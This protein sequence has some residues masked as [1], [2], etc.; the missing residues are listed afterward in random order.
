MVGTVQCERCKNYNG[1]GTCM[2]Y[3]HISEEEKKKNPWAHSIPDA[4]FRGKTKH[5]K[6]YPGDNGIQ[7][8]EK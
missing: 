2:A 4:I 1:D 6:P 5:D 8:V 7:F 3:P